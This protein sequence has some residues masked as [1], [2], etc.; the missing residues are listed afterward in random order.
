VNY[1]KTEKSFANS[2]RQAN[3]SFH[4]HFS[5]KEASTSKRLHH[6]SYPVNGRCFLSAMIWLS[7][8]SQ[9]M[10]FSKLSLHPGLS[11]G[12]PGIRGAL[13]TLSVPEVSA[14]DYRRTDI[15]D[16]NES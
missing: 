11:T 3:P 12:L 2:A 16:S 8:R 14:C 5:R 9:Q 6:S 7:R 4:V 10:A 15:S 13:L 1:S